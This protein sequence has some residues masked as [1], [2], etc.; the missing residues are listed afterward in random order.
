MLEYDELRIRMRNL[1]TRRY[2]VL[3]NGP[4]AAAAGISLDKEPTELWR[5]YNQLIGMEPA[6]K[7][8]GDLAVTRRS[9]E[10]GREVF[11]IL[12]P[13]P[14]MDCL[15]DAANRAHAEGRRLRLRFD[16]P[17]ELSDLPIESL[18]G[19][20]QSPLQGIA[21]DP[22]FSLVRSLRGGQRRTRLSGRPA[23]V[24]LLAAAASPP[25]LPL[26]P[27][28]ELTGLYEALPREA[29]SLTKLNNA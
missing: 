15:K 17:G 9:R 28:D 2:V 29:A 3:A 26:D 7:P 10:L 6:P 1:G 8:A 27:S 25:D 19:P 21:F 11:D 12:F 22:G 13:G 18:C 4:A 16:L 20:A 23:R 24:H 5:R 14:V